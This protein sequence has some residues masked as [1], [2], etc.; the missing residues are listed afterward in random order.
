M[1]T[2]TGIPATIDRILSF[3]QTSKIELTSSIALT[4]SGNATEYEVQWPRNRV[5]DAGLKEG[6]SVKLVPTALRIFNQ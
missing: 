6:M 5:M 3:G 4:E 2:Q 1:R